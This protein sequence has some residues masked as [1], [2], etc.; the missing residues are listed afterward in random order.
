[1][2]DTTRPRWE[3]RGCGAVEYCD[4]PGYRR[5]EFPPDAARKALIRRHGQCRGEIVYHAGVLPFGRPRGQRAK[6]IHQKLTGLL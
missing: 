5:F 1:M 3:C 6:N 2:T 4:E